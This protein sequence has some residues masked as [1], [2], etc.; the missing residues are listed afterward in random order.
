MSELRSG[1]WAL[2]ESTVADPMI[3]ALWDPE[4]R[5]QPCWAWPSDLQSC[6][7][8]SGCCLKALR[9]QKLLCSKRWR[10]EAGKIQLP[11]LTKLGGD[12]ARIWTQDIWLPSECSLRLP[13]ILSPACG[14]LVQMRFGYT[15][16]VEWLPSFSWVMNYG[17]SPWNW[18][19]WVSWVRPSLCS[20]TL[21]SKDKAGECREG[22]LHCGRERHRAR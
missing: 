4:Q 15:Q 6:E 2:G 5:G 3:L 11:R 10:T 21:G 8:M 20:P 18:W 1:P 19:W 13:V 17:L 22:T 12:R 14:V 9:V 16:R 7:P